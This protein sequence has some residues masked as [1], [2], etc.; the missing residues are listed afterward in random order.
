MLLEIVIWLVIAT[1]ALSAGQAWA[2]S[3]RNHLLRH[4]VVWIFSTTLIVLIAAPIVGLPTSMSLGWITPI[5]FLVSALLTAVS[6][7]IG[8]WLTSSDSPVGTPWLVRMRRLVGVHFAIVSVG[9]AVI[10]LLLVFLV[11]GRIH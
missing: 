11:A 2:M 9:G 10:W 4:L 6:L 5:P 8:H 1:L 7:S 3:T